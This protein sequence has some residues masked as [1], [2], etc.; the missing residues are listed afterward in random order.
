MWNDLE[1][2]ERVRVPHEFTSRIQEIEGAGLNVFAM[3]HPHPYKVA[4]RTMPLDTATV[5]VVKSTDP[6]IMSLA[7]DGTILPRRTGS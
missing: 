2:A 7:D 4:G 5:Y 6:G 1:P 3:R